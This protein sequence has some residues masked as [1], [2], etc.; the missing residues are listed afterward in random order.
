M[1]PLHIT[2]DTFQKEVLESDIP[3]LVDFWASWCAPCRMIAPILDE[4]A[5]QFEGKVKIAKMNTDENMTAVNYGIMSIPTLLIFKDGKVVD[6]IVGAVPK[7]T[8]VE[9]LEYFAAAAVNQI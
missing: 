5:P 9:K 4:I 2:D 3:V 7:L 1:K 8:I 6:Q